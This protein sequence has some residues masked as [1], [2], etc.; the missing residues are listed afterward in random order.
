[1]LKDCWCSTT[2]SCRWPLTTINLQLQSSC[3]WQPSIAGQIVGP[4]FTCPISLVS[5]SHQANRWKTIVDLFFLS[6]RIY[7]D[8]ALPLSLQSVLW[9]CRYDWL[10]CRGSAISSTTLT[11]FNSW[12]HLIQK[13]KRWQQHRQWSHTLK[14]LEILMASNNTKSPATCVTFRTLTD[15]CACE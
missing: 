7:V 1:M 12:E 9:C 13:R 10:H 14:Q 8:H 11:T 2:L 6:G 5:N 15:M 4:N 3:H